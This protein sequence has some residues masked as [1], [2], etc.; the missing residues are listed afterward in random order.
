MAERD[1]EPVKWHVKTL[2]KDLDMANDLA[3]TMQSSIPMAG[4]GAE[5][6]RLHGSQGNL[7][8]DPC[9]LVE[10]YTEKKD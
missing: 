6:M 2:L 9:T 7:D 10:M 4:L 3:K 5:L 1:F 8:R